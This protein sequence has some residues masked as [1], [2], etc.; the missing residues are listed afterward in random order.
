[1]DEKF[2]DAFRIFKLLEARF[3][4]NLENFVKEDSAKRFKSTI[5]KLYRLVFL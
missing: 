4:S 3:S 2:D 5:T 1:M